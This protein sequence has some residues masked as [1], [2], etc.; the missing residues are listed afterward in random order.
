MKELG[1]SFLVLVQKARNTKA[2]CGEEVC[3]LKSQTVVQWARENKVLLIL[4]TVTGTN[5]AST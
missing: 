4:C 3:K 1:N 5:Q 2:L